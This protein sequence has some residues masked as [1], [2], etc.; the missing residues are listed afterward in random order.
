MQFIGISTLHLRTFLQLDEDGLKQKRQ[1]RLMKAGYEARER[2]KK[3]K[4]RER[5]E[6][7]AEERREQE[8]RERDLAGWS[9]RLR[10]EQEVCRSPHVAFARSLTCTCT[11]D[12]EQDQGA[13]PEEACA[14]GPQ[15]RCVAGA[16]EE[17]RQ[18]GGGRSRPEE[19]EEDWGW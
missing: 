4:E 18:L 19:A 14:G 3:E 2:A 8:E 1:Q 16:D 5:E 11:D 12:H 9:N 10:K 15:E 7:L 17:H 6:K 13:E